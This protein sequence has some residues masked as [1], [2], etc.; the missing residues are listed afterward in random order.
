MTSL[1]AAGIW[2]YYALATLL[3]HLSIFSTLL[4]VG[5]LFNANA[6]GHA[7]A[8]DKNGCHFHKTTGK[9]HCHGKPATEKRASA[10][11]QKAPAPGDDEVLYGRVVSVTDGDTFKAKIQGVVMNFRMADI[12][13]PETDQPF[14]G[15]ARSML[16]AVLDGRD[17]V[18]VR[19][20]D[21]PYSR[22]VVQVW[23]ANLHVNREVMARGAAW[24][25]REYAND[26]CLYQ[27]ENV[28]RDAKRG[29]WSLPLE[30]RIEPWVW[31]QRK[32]GAATALPPRGSRAPGA[33]GR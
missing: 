17:V 7:G 18:M 4:V 5:F 16:T 29:L 22:F 30:K 8:V 13:A 21:D 31:R 14:G 19:V 28:A 33:R 32:R 11:S 23:I 15:E 26:D 12:D 27:V 10:C 25:D 9:R 24:F 6:F 3:K 2:L 20:D 1:V